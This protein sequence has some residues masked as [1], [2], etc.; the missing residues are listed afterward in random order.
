MNDRHK[1][2]LLQEEKEKEKEKENMIKLENEINNKS[3]TNNVILSE[4]QAVNITD[5]S[6]ERIINAIVKEVGE[7]QLLKI[8]IEENIQRF[9]IDRIKRLTDS[10]NANLETDL[11]TNDNDDTLNL[12]SNYVSEWKVSNEAHNKQ[13]SEMVTRLQQIQQELSQLK[14]EKND[15]M[16]NGATKEDIKLLY[17]QLITHNEQL[18]N[19]R[20]LQEYLRNENENARN[21]YQQVREDLSEIKVQ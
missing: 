21:M 3:M 8:N 12:I 11:D 9:D 2:K 7:M 6:L 5:E 13:L 20:K 18:E 10:Q 15:F 14:A 1:Q 19:D 16:K 4:N 17:N